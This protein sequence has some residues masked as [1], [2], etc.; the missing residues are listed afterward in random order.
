MDPA[1]NLLD[2]LNWWRAPSGVPPFSFAPQFVFDSGLERFDEPEWLWWVRQN[3]WS[4]AILLEHVGSRDG[5]A[6]MFE[7]TDPVTNLR[8][9]IA[10]FAHWDGK[11]LVSVVRVGTPIQAGREPD[12]IRG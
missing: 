3:P 7:A 1:P 9:R 5:E 8:H 4:D 12:S 11:A 2:V 10:W 6:I